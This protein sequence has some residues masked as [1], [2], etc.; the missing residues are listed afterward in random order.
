MSSQ[1]QLAFNAMYSANIMLLVQQKGSRLKDAVRQEMVTGEIAYFDQIGAGSAIKR[2]SRHADTPLTET[3]HARRQVMLEDYEYSDLVDRLDQVKTLTDPTNAY[4]QAAAHAL[5]RAMDD[6]IIAQANGVARSGKTGQTLVTLPAPQKIA[7]GGT[8]LTLAKLL[9]AK[10]I[11]D[12]AENDPDEPRYVA[13]P[14]KDITV[15]L[16]TTQVT[17]SDYNT[18]KALAAGQIDTFLGFRFIR[19]QRLGL[20]GSGERACLAWRQSALLLALAQSPKVKVTERPDKSYATQVY[21]AMSIGATR[22]EEDGVVE[23]GTLA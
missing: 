13:C 18:V 12:A 8:G 21:C 15:L 23:I 10:E 3:P 5:G 22:M 4:A 17:S 20:N 7:G 11:L 1:V 16:G 14:A 6:V 19:T 2:Q 9:Q